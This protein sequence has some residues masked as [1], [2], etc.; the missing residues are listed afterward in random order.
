M[1][2]NYL[3]I[4]WRNIVGNPLFSAINIIGLSIGLACCII[5]TL[6]VR[7]ETSFDKHWQDGDR[8]YRVTRDFFANNLQ[9]AAVAPPIAPLLK[10]DF[11]DIEDATRI[12]A[13][14]VT[15]IRGDTQ[16][17]EPGFAI[18]DPNVFEFFNLNFVDG[19]A[20]S[21]LARP[22]NIVL[23]ERAADR[24]FGDEDPMGQTL[25]LMG[26]ADV[27]VAAIIE[28]LPDN[29]HMTFEVM[30]SIDELHL[31][32]RLYAEPG[33]LDEPVEKVMSPPMPTVGIGQS[34]QL[35]VSLLDTCNALLV[36]DG[37][38]PKAVVSRS[39]V[40]RYLSPDQP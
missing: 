32:D 26:Q 17:R 10:E 36:L 37:G 13:T 18:A 29:T 19:D 24:Y 28:D 5:I 40:L 30:G 22:T 9:L 25:N 11:A 8:I 21:A 27:T 1:L 39:D 31:M 38:R 14:D 33:V 4:A 34:V 16:I 2:K 35:A 6:F 12:L 7:Y 15:I 20:A 3:Q 23:T